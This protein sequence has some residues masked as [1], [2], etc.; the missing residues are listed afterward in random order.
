MDGSPYTGGAA[1]AEPY[2]AS[3]LTREI[4]HLEPGHMGALNYTLEEFQEEFSRYHRAGHHVAVHTQGE[5]AVALVL[6]AAEQVLAAHPWNDHRHRLEHNAL[7]TKEQIARAKQLGFELSFFTE[8]IYFYG[9]RL[10]EIVGDRTERYMP[11]GS[12]FAE[13]HRATIH[14][15]NPMTPIDPLRVIENAVLRVPRK[16][17][18]S[19]GASERLNIDQAVAAM[20]T[21]A[22]WQLGVE[23]HRGSL[24]VGKAADLVLLSRNPLKTPPGTFGD[25]EVI[26]TWIDGQPVDT[27]KA[28]LPNLRIAV[29]AIRQLLWPEAMNR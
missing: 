21:N 24:E 28:S 5:R 29:R 12:A 22:A 16:G 8:H 10:P 26:A 25:I 18:D 6:D 7:I 9:D 11:V 15:D 1:F 2:E 19:L 14:S 23:E 20:T 3:E 27:R 13:G 17:G 4:M